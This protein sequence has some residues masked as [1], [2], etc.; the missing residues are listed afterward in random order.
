MSWMKGLKLSALALLLSGTVVGLAGF[1]WGHFACH[2][3]KFMKRIVDAHV[4][5]ALDKIDATADQ[6]QKVSALE[7]KLI[8]DF[9]AMRQSH[10]A[11][12]SKVVDQFPQDSLDPSVLDQAMA[13]QKQ[14]MDQLHQDVRQSLIDLHDLLTPVQRQ[15]L[16]ALAK[17]RLQESDC[18][19]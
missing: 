2:G 4:E 13:D 16:A 5:E 19:Q 14:S 6:R 8:G 10:R 3:Q 12:F 9:K 11:S 17:E 1:G 15:K 18:G 7:D